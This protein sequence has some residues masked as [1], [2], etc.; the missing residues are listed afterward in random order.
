MDGDGVMMEI[1]FPELQEVEQRL[2]HE[3]SQRMFE[4][5]QTMRLHL[6]GKEIYNLY[7][8]DFRLLNGQ[9]LE[10]YGYT[11]ELR[12][13]VSYLPTIFD[14]QEVKSRNVEELKR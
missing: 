11:D 10:Y 9:L 7:Q 6:L 1:M 14:L 4:R 12:K 8:N 2:K 5:Y 13:M 3:K